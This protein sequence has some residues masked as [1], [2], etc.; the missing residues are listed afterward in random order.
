MTTKTDNAFA[1]E[2]EARE[3]QQDWP[4]RLRNIVEVDFADFAAEVAGAAAKDVTRIVESL[5]AGDIIILKRTMPKD[6]LVETREK[7][8]QYGVATA[9]EYH[10]MLEGC[11]DYHRLIDE[12]VAKNYSFVAIKHSYYFFPWNEDRF[13]LLGET[14]KRWTSIKVAS[15][16]AADEYRNNTPKDGIVDRLQVVHYPAGA[17]RIETH[18]DPYKIQRVIIS[19][20]MSKRGEDYDTG[21]AYFVDADGVEVDVED[22]LDSG[23]WIIY[24][25]TVLHGVKTVDEDV[26]PDWKT[27]RGRWWFGP[28]SNASNEIKDR[29]TGY[30]VKEVEK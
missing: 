10:K 16:L 8:H 28:F 24:A 14:Y 26:V 19:G 11:P 4:T 30:A 27:S 13:L 29:H 2:W 23:D 12:E 22:R 6:F 9:S 3:S 5:F 20:I 7:L 17:G 15:G 18:S 21:G 25:P 1:R